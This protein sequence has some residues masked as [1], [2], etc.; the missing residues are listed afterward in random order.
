MTAIPKITEDIP[1]TITDTSSWKRANPPIAKSH[2]QAIE[3]AIN[4]R[5]RK[6]RKEKS[7]KDNI[8]VK[9]IMTDKILSDFI[10]FALATAITGPPII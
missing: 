6:L 5:L 4:K 1:I 10:C 3:R 2:P 8:N 9:E 7:N